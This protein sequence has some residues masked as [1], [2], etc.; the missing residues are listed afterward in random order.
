M[1]RTST[2]TVNNIIND[3]HRVAALTEDGTV[4]VKN[5]IEHGA[6]SLGTVKNLFGAFSN[7]KFAEILNMEQTN[8]ALD[9]STVRM[10]AVKA[11]KDMGKAGVK[12]NTKTFNRYARGIDSKDVATLYGS[13]AAGVRELGYEVDEVAY[14]APRKKRSDAK[15]AA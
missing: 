7:E 3:V 9:A 2:V 11:I 15:V 14:V 6:F 13:F 8:D 4:R 5:Y 10:L 1:A 12:T